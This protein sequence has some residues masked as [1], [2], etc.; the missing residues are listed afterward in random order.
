M[1]ITGK[2]LNFLMAC[3]DI[4]DTEVTDKC[5]GALSLIWTA[6]KII[7]MNHADIAQCE[8]VRTDAASDI[9]VMFS[10]RGIPVKQ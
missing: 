10:K 2:F 3:C 7:M 5:L 4:A 1:L 8:A 6:E 9:K